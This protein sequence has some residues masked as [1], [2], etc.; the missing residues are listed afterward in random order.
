[1]AQLKLSAFADEYSNNFDKQIEY[2]VQNNIDYI[3]LR[4]LDGKNIA[5]MNSQEVEAAAQKLEAAGIGVSSIGS[6]LGK[7]NIED[8]FDN[9][10]EKAKRV[11]EAANIVGTKNIRM[12]SFYLP[13]GKTREQCRDW[14]LHR[15]DK[16]AALAQQ[17]NVTLCHENEAKIYGESPEQCLDILSHFSGTIKCVFDMGN[18][19]LDGYKPFPDAY[20]LLKDYIEYFHI[21]D[22][23]YA[24]AIVPPGCGE[25]GIP[26]IFE[27]VK[28]DFD[29]DIFVTLE[30]HLQTF[31]GLNQ[32]VGKTFDN[33]YKFETGEIAF[34]EAVKRIKEILA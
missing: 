29:R 19:V 33:P 25:A 28:Q 26:E 9:H 8:D 13:E 27:A 5:D 7:I 14:V 32:L 24:G 15:L 11:F 21:K 3:E 18:F 22:S 6:P 4:F 17:Y 23:L 34:E 12:F 31:D 16:L 2:L 30:P 1:M 20:N 10:M